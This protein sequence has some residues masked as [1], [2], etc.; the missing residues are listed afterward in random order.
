LEAIDSV[1]GI[2]IIKGYYFRDEEGSI[3]LDEALARRRVEH[4][5]QSV[6]ISGN[7]IMVQVLP[8]EINADVRTN[9][10]E[11]LE[12]E[13][14]GLSEVYHV[15]GDSVEICFPI[16]DS[17]N[18]PPF[19]W[20]KLNDWMSKHSDQKA[21]DVFVVGI[22]DGSGIAE[23]SDM[24]LVRAILVQKKMVNSGWSENKI[25]LSTGQRNNPLVIRNRCVIVFI[26]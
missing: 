14:I 16:K 10:F 4:V 18:L 1:H 25:H 15:S 24:A 8:K 23:S 3:P 12:V 9:P 6:G 19:L 17:L 20:N 2:L 11:A 22:A 7:K 13:P 26:E 21:S 5:L